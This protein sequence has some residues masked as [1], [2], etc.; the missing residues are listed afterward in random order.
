VLC[1]TCAVVPF[2]QEA[3]SQS[4]KAAVSEAQQ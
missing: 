4:V 1:D 2:M 3:L